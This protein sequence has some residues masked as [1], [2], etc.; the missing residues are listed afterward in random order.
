MFVEATSNEDP[1]EDFVSE[2]DADAVFEMEVPIPEDA[3]L[4]VDVDVPLLVPDDVSKLSCVLKVRG[5][6]PSNPEKFLS[7]CLMM[8][9][10]GSGRLG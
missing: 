2:T 9:G 1:I 6:T 8:T 7:D 4:E 5:E 3:T 10:G